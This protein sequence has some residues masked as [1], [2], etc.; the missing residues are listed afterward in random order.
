MKNPILLA[1]LVA[2]AA[3]PGL[4]A[5]LSMVSFNVENYQ[6]ATST[7]VIATENF[8]TF[9][10][11]NVADGFTTGVG[12]FASL[13]GMGSGGTIKNADFENDGS[14]LA[15][16]DSRVYGRR[17][18][19]QYLTGHAGAAAYLDSNATEGIGWTAS[20][21]GGMFNRLVFSLT[22][23]AD[24]GGILELVVGDVLYRLENQR[25]GKKWLVTIDLEE[26][27]SSVSVFFRNVD[28]NGGLISGD[29][30]SLDDI[31]LADVPLPASAAL[32]LAGLGGIA[33][34]RRKGSAKA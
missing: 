15:V 23:A 27:V 22:D 30:F 12:A 33:V 25:A 8:E 29:G 11:G 32:L 14:L 13:G 19:T 18:T 31:A 2:L 16:R 1:C 28:A 3:T 10:E 7:G 24:E 4:G 5:T 20:A 21:A 17:S 34:F 26:A 9:G 6:K